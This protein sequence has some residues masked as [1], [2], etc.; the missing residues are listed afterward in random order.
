M[1]LG[2]YQDEDSQASCKLLA[3]F[4]Q[5]NDSI[6]WPEIVCE[7][8][9]EGKRCLACE[10]ENT[11]THM[12]LRLAFCPVGY[13]Q[14]EP[15]AHCVRSTMS[16]ITKTKLENRPARMRPGHYQVRWDARLLVSS[17]AKDITRTSMLLP[18]ARVSDGPGCGCTRGLVM[19]N[20]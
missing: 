4:L 10:A 16:V 13:V 14:P 11:R 15:K 19:C 20:L 17:A 3:R 7:D 1:Q 9:T 18:D 12:A 8:P 5:T 2:F 6:S